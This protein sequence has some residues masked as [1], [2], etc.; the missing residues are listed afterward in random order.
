M[1][2][3]G[4]KHAATVHL[5][6]RRPGWP[7]HPHR[8]TPRQAS[9]DALLIFNGIGANLELVFPFVAALDPDLEVIAFDVPG[10]GGSSTPNH[11][12]AFRA[13]PS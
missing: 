12:I 6:H 3:Q 5:P 8:G 13:W 7:D 11:R 4:L 10:V 1:N 9:L 2:S